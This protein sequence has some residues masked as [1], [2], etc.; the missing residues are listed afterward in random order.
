MAEALGL[1]EAT[2]LARHSRRIGGRRSLLERREGDRYDCAFLIREAGKSRC[3][4]YA[5][6]PRQCRTW[7]FWSENLASPEAWA[8][9][10]RRT[11]C[12][13]MDSGPLHTL[14]TITASAAERS[15]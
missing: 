10:K 2:F 9:T 7:P 14:V 4:I 15:P 12:P 1:D 13:G 11:P 6:R 3:A 8:E 5:V